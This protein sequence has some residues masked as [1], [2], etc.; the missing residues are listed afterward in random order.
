MRSL[1]VAML[2]LVLAGTAHSHGMQV[3][4]RVSVDS[5]S[6]NVQVELIDPY[7]NPTPGATV[8]VASGD[9]GATP[10]GGWATLTEGEPGV[11][12]GAL[13]AGAGGSRLHM[14]VEWPGERWIGE[15]RLHG[16]GGPIDLIP[17]E[18]NAGVP[19]WM[20]GGMI[21]ALAVIA[22]GLWDFSRHRGGRSA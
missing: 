9:P 4:A 14:S 12:Q 18:E 3:S 2:L 22:W 17:V 16:Q 8:K 10:A 19:F 15:T 1:I 21:L 11:H 13:P 20:T 6:G 7:S 5:A